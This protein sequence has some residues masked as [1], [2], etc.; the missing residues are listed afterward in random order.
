MARLERCARTTLS[1]PNWSLTNPARR[2]GT[3]SNPISSGLSNGVAGSVVSL[4][5]GYPHLAQK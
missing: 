1:S 4:L 3:K 5:E 2:T